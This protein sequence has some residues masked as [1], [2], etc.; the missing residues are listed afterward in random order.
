MKMSKQNRSS[1]L[2]CLIDESGTLLASVKEPF[3]VGFLVTCRPQCFEHD[4]QTLKKELPPLGKHGE[5][6]AREDPSYTRAMLRHLLCLN[7]EPL[8]YIVEWIKE[9]FSEE[10]F[11]NGKLRVFKDTNPVIASFAVIASE[12]AVTASAN[13]FSEIHI[14][15]EAIKSDIKS[16]HRSREQALNS[17]L[18]TAFERQST[19]KVPPP[20]TRTII[21]VSTKRK[22]EYPPLSFV[23]YWLWAYCKHADQNDEHA[24]PSALKKRTFVER[25]TELSIKSGK[26]N[27]G[28]EYG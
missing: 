15:S 18:R 14:I 23:D 10:H 3:R 11:E 6:H 13:G 9:E 25:M 1:T 28:M 5:Y 22:K 2:M 7:T 26:R 16:E 8:M 21:K 4:I 17:V 20:G 27:V 24:L 19:I 12:F